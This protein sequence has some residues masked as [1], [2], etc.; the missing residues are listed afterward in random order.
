MKIIPFQRNKQQMV[1]NAERKLKFYL[2]FPQGLAPV[3][4]LKFDSFSG[5]QKLSKLRDLDS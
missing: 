3:L 2:V 5:R 1:P 4:Q